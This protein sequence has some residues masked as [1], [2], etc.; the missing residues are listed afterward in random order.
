MPSSKDKNSILIVD[1]EKSNIIALSMILSPDYTVYAA[2][3]GRDAIEIA[4]EYLPDVILLDILMPE[5][6]GYDIIA[7]L[8]EIEETE[9]IPV[10]FVTGLT[11]VGSEEKGLDLGAAD[12]IIK[13]FSPA[14]VKL[15]VRNQMKIVNQIRIIN[16]LSTTDQLTGIPNRRSF[17]IQMGK[18]WSRNMREN[19]PLSFLMIDVD[20]FKN[21]ND[22]FG[23]QAGDD[24][25]QLV[26]RTLTDSLRRAADF[27]ARWGGE[28]FA[29]LLP[30][31]DMDGAAENA[32]R[33][34][35]NVEKAQLTLPYG[36]TTSVTVSIG[37]ST[38][39]PTNDVSYNEIIFQ[40]D[41]ALY[42]AKETGRNRVVKFK[43]D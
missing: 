42:E 20:K 9:S 24:L 38:I 33:I 4:Q 2:K 5:M 13:P 41:K 22:T 11:N 29:I 25:L 34:R 15:R 14:I 30:N 18:E 16:H 7:K 40:A 35:A 3:N 31:T 17:N 26:A 39:I 27:A 23:H 43:S 37:L 12:Y 36:K 32:E 1:D 19:S 21:F 10:I 6:D 8:K 28:E